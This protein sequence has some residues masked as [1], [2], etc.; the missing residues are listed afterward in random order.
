L[1]NITHGLTFSPILFEIEGLTI[2]LLLGWEEN[3][4]LELPLQLF[5]SSDFPG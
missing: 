4:T 1:Y 2:K 3:A 5:T